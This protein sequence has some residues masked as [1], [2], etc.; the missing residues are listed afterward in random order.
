MSSDECEMTCRCC[1]GNN[2]TT[3]LFLTIHADF[4]LCDLY[5]TLSQLELNEDDGLPKMLCS[6]C[7]NLVIQ[8]NAFRK[9]AQESETYLRN[10]LLNS[11]KEGDEFIA[12]AQSRDNDV[13]T[14]NN[15][16]ILE[17]NDIILEN[18]DITGH[19]DITENDDINQFL[20]E[21]ITIESDTESSCEKTICGL[22]FD[23][24]SAYQIHRKKEARQETNKKQVTICQK[25]IGSYELKDHLNFHTNGRP[26]K[27]QTCSETFRFR[28]S[29]TCHEFQHTG[30]K[31]HFCHICGMSFVQASTLTGHM[32][33]H[34]GEIG[35]KPFMCNICGRGFVENLELDNHINKVHTMKNGDGIINSSD[36]QC[37][38]C[39][40]A[41]SSKSGL[42]QHKKTHCER[43]FL[44]GECGK[45]FTTKTLLSS[46]L[47]T[48]SGVR[49]YPCHV[50]GKSFAQSSSLDKHILVHTGEKPV[51]CILCGKRFAQQSHLIYHMRRHSGEKP[52][53]CTYCDKM[54]S[55]SG[56]LKVHTRIHTGEKPFVCHI[57][58]RGFYDSSSMKK[59]IVKVHAA[60]VDNI[61][62]EIME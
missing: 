19:D 6:N 3:D 1:L 53:R 55:H 50:C 51:L 11:M 46:H 59:H 10:A 40:K 34:Y 57:C 45:K 62:I 48:H 33:T 7:T 58:S 13:K 29:L 41:F 43:K 14:G 39:N 24:H 30:K 42:N 35:E 25:P 44:C 5:S 22:K 36:L 16:I 38:E 32:H 2:G 21:V 20:Q 47:K 12:E 60:E 49:P 26:H 17:N 15:D 56:T 23:T 8:F 27:C 31:P 37:M 61:E 28:S 18:N 9:Q 54:F 52:Y 4:L